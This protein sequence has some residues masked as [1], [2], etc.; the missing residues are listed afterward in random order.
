MCPNMIDKF[1][2]S[3]AVFKE[4]NCFHL[5]VI[6]SYDLLE[7]YGFCFSMV[8]R[9]SCLYIFW[10]LFEHMVH[11]MYPSCGLSGKSIN[12]ST[13]CWTTEMSWISKKVCCL[14]SH[15]FQRPCT[16]NVSEGDPQNSSTQNFLLYIW[17]LWDKRIIV[18]T[19]QR[20]DVKFSIILRQHKWQ[21]SKDK[22]RIKACAW[23]IHGIT[24][25]ETDKRYMNPQR[26]FH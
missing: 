13:P 9:A 8:S 17:A 1:K 21:A 7:F 6:P 11:L 4:Q 19:W 26:K 2:S 12:T 18:Y 3:T 15:V 23:H 20:L 10:W 25:S 14:K 24:K 16:C 5:C 22:R